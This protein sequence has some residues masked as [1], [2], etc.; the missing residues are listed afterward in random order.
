MSYYRRRPR[1]EEP[2]HELRLP[3]NGQ[4]LGKVIRISGASKFVVQCSDGNERVC[5]IPGRLKRRFWI[6]AND[7]VIVMPWVVQSNERGDIVWKYSLMDVGRLKDR[8][9][10]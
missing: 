4:V 3:E 5:S 10:I 1:A 9:L 8:K 2:V 7:V 6:R